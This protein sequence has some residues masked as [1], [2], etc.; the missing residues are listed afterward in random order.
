LELLFNKKVVVLIN[1]DSDFISDS[2]KGYSLILGMTIPITVTCGIFADEVILVL[3]GAKWKDTIDIFRLFSP[4]IIAFALINPFG[5]LLFSTGNVVRSLKIAVSIALSLIGG[6][7]I[8]MLYGPTGMASGFSIMMILWIVP[9]IYWAKQGSSLS[10]KDIISA[11]KPPLISG[12][13]A[14]IIAYGA[15]Y[16]LLQ[17]LIMYQKLILEIIIL[18]SVYIYFLLYIMKQKKFYFGIMSELK[19]RSPS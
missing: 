17:Q 18:F 5:W 15:Q 11:A 16:W 4:T 9:A 3:L 19:H 6:Y 2:L 8:G 12:L 7:T 10:F 13:S 14:G 1:F